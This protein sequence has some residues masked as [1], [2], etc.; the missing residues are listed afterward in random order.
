VLIQEMDLSLDLG[1]VYALADLVTK[2]EVTEKTEVRCGVTAF[3]R[4]YYE[5]RRSKKILQ[6]L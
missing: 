1:F 4:K 2:A 3:V 6:A 5:K